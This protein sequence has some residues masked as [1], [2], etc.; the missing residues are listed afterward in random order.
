LLN[1]DDLKQAENT[2]MFS[3]CFYF[4]WLTYFR[5]M[6]DSL[7]ALEPPAIEL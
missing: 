3:A 1:P 7:N 5:I 2:T 6:C 4:G